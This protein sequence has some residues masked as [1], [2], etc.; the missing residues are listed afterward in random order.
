MACDRVERADK[1]SADA[2]FVRASFAGCGGQ[3]AEKALW[4][5]GLQSPLCPLTGALSP[6]SEVSSPR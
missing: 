1:C 5:L 6:V 4:I 2:R 3:Y